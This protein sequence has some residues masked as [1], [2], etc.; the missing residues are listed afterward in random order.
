ME[1]TQPTL[2]VNPAYVGGYRRRHRCDMIHSGNHEKGQNMRIMRLAAVVLA[3][4]CGI[5]T[6]GSKQ[7]ETFDVWL[8]AGLQ[9]DVTGHVQDTQCEEQSKVHAVPAESLAHV[10]RTWE[11]A[12]AHALR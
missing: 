1:P 4:V 5:A 12:P 9:I 10:L 8:R 11:F 2:T 6:A 7:T 3:A